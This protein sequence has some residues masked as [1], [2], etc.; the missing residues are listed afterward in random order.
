MP[1]RF[2]FSFREPINPEDLQ[3]LYQQTDWANNRTPIDI[4]QMLE[5]SNLVLGVW[6][7][8]KLIGFARVNTDDVYRAWIDDVV[9]DSNY[10]KQG[11]GSHIIQKLLKRLQHI[12]LVMLDCDPDLATFYEKHGF[13]LNQAT[14]MQIRHTQ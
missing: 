8:D 7:D 13:K 1:E 5:N 3:N 4:Q 10:R 9:V 6:D 11:V 12:E 14:S 2:T